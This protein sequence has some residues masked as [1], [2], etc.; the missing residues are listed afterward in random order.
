MF[1]F[2]RTDAMPTVA[3]QPPRA[4]SSVQTLHDLDAEDEKF[5]LTLQCLRWRPPHRTKRQAISVG[6]R[7]QPQTFNIEDD[8][9]QTYVFT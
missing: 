8:E 2:P 6:C 5:T 3:V 9:T 1:R 4:P 7:R